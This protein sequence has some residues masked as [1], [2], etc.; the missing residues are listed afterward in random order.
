[1]DNNY[2]LDIQMTP[3]VGNDLG[4]QITKQ[5]PEI[6]A[7]TARKFSDI[8]NSRKELHSRKKARKTKKEYVTDHEISL[9]EVRHHTVIQQHMTNTPAW[10]TTI[11]RR[12]DEMQTA[13][14]DLQTIT[15][16]LDEMQTFIANI[17][18]KRRN[19]EDPQA[20]F[21]PLHKAKPG[22]GKN[23]AAPILA[24]QTFALEP[25]DIIPPLSS[26][27]QEHGI[28][29]PSSV[30]TASVMTHQQILDLICFYNDTMNIVAADNIGSRRSKVVR[31]LRGQ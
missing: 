25:P 23:L 12:L 31:W 22:W 11:T 15:K 17:E 29:C 2:T 1:M 21:Q 28:T 18:I 27:P 26:L 5:A 24:P 14:A 19:R 7:G 8:K 10:M 6:R 9:A 16:R 30:V 4:E 3:G 20:N 13:I